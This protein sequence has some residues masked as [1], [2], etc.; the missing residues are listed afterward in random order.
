MR[1]ASL[2]RGR[3]GTGNVGEPDEPRRAALASGAP[4]SGGTKQQQ[5]RDRRRVF[6][7]CV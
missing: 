4:P 3:A 5:Q 1:G 2:G 6:G 7:E